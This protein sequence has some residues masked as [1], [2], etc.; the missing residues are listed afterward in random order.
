MAGKLCA[1]A[2]PMATGTISSASPWTM[3]TAGGTGR[4]ARVVNAWRLS[5]RSRSKAVIGH[6]TM[7]DAISYMLVNGAR[8]TMAV[9]QKSPC[10]C[11][12][13]RRPPLTQL[14][15]LTLGLSKR[16]TLHAES[17]AMRSKALPVLRQ[18]LGGG[19]THGIAYFG[20]CRGLGQELPSALALQRPLG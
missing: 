12:L 3:V 1:R 13:E 19:L 6:T 14:I 7:C 15:Q 9:P 8:S 18:V 20:F 4:W 5:N 2:R 17:L 11:R 16:S 10:A